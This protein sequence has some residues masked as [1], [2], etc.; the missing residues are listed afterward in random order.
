MAKKNT[1]SRKGKF[2]VKKNRKNAS[3]RRKPARKKRPARR[4]AS[5]PGRRSRPKTILP[6]GRRSSGD[7]SL[8]APAPSRRRG[9]GGRSAGQSGDTQGLSDAEG[10]DFESVEELAEEGQ[11]FEAGV[12]D[13]VEAADDSQREVGTR[14]VLEDDVPLEYLDED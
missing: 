6:A 3:T 1:T 11:N 9:L 13:G 12:V 7:L 2:A 14:E 8:D 10:A 5:Q 4:K